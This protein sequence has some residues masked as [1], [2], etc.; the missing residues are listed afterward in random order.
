METLGAP[1]SSSTSR[2][3]F[4]QLLSRNCRDNIIL[5]PMNSPRLYLTWVTGIVK[6]LCL[7][8]F[9]G[10]V[11]T[12]RCGPFPRIDYAI[13]YF[14]P[15]GGTIMQ[16]GWGPDSKWAPVSEVWKF[17]KTGWNSVA[18]STAPALVHHAMAFDAARNVLIVCGQTNLFK[19]PIQQWE[20][21]GISWKARPDTPM[22]A[23]GSIRL[24]YDP[25]R[26]RT[27]AYWAQF[28]A[29][30]TG[31][32][33]FEYDGANWMKMSPVQKP[34]HSLERGFMR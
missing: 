29:K 32:E 9:L 28:T 24:A 10:M 5:N 18:G 3:L 26:K 13:S 6:L 31:V 21:D 14:P 20:F 34:F 16:G 33:T 30:G 23:E 19:S 2:E 15:L 27:V 11:A 12:G 7:F 22:N 17:D 8:A 1:A 4:W 25:I